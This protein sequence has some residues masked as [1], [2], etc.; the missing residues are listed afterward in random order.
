VAVGNAVDS[1]MVQ[2]VNTINSIS[3][4]Y[5]EP[6]IYDQVLK[7][8]PL[9]YRF[10]RKGPKIDGRPA[11]QWPCITG[12]KQNGGTYTGAGQ[13]AHGVE[14]LIQPAEV[15]WRHY[16]EDVTIPKTD[17]LKCG[18]ADGIADLVKVSFDNAIINLRK[19]IGQDMYAAISP[20]GLGLDHLGMAIDDGSN[21]ASYAG[22]SH[23]ATNSDGTFFW[24]PGLDGDGY[25][26]IGGNATFNMLQDY[27]SRASDGDLEPT[28]MMV[29]R[30]GRNF[31]W[32]QMQAL[33]QYIHD[34][35]MTKAGFEALQFNRAVV[36]VDRY[37]PAN[38]VFFLNE[39]MVDLVTLRGDNFVI[40]PIISGTPSERSINTKICYSGNLRLRSPRYFAKMTTV[41]NM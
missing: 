13:L 24:K 29:T 19:R 23:T 9:L 5:I 26:A 4:K 7:R 15:L 37:M 1:T 36:M 14:D 31:V 16:Y 28:L 34:E 21:F 18:G 39:E 2:L 22:I 35:E 33:Q 41:T 10:W 40:D 32:S 20:G 12:T 25:A 27:Y 30:A 6:T 17:I 8:S 3:Q 38:T 11:I